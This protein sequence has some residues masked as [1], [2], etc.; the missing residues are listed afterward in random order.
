MILTNGLGPTLAFFMAKAPGKP[1]YKRL[2]DA[3]AKWVLQDSNAQMKTLMNGIING[4][5][6]LYSRYTR[7]TLA[8][9]Q[10]L[11]RFAE[12]KNS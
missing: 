10:W 4:N 2:G 9:M 12:A 3:V 5:A 7:E 8:Y 6:D 11:K 1:E